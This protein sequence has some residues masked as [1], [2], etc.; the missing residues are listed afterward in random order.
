MITDLEPDSLECE[1]KWA[2]ESI[3]TN[4]ASESDRVDSPGSMHD[5]GCLGLVHWDG[6]EGW[7]EEGGGC[8]HTETIKAT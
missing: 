3:T 6:P 7:D 1:V 4:K 8:L 2:L 5:A